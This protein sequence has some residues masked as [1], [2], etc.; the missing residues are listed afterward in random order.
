MSLVMAV[1][2]STMSNIRHSSKLL[3]TQFLLGDVAGW[4]EFPRTTCSTWEEP[5]ISVGELLVA[6]LLS[7]IFEVLAAAIQRLGSKSNPERKHK[8]EIQCQR[9][10]VFFLRR[11]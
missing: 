8:I 5:G 4:R 10:K 1:P 3:A 6:V 11:S 7:H 2:G 9:Q